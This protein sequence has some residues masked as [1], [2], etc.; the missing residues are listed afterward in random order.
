MKIFTVS[1]YC[2]KIDQTTWSKLE[3]SNIAVGT[4]NNSNVSLMR[5][6]N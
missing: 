2:N 3:S 4:V 6:Y 1:I 5:E